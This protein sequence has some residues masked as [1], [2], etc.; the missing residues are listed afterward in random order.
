MPYAPFL[1]NVDGAD[2][3]RTFRVSAAGATNVSVAAGRVRIDQTVTNFAAA[4]ALG[5]LANGTNYIYIDNGGNITSSITGC[6]SAGISQG[7]SSRPEG[8]LV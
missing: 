1:H 5:P 3:A 7:Q 8:Q 6:S 4:T 2:H